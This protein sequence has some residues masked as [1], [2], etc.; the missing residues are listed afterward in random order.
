MGLIPKKLVYILFSTLL[1]SAVI[2]F[3]SQFYTLNVSAATCSRH[4][5]MAYSKTVPATCSKTGSK[6]TYCGN[7]SGVVSTKTIAKLAHTFSG[8]YTTTKAATCTSTGTKVGKCSKCSAVVSTVTIAKKS[9]SYTTLKPKCNAE[10]NSKYCTKCKGSYGTTIA[11]TSH[12]WSTTRNATCIAEGT[13]KCGGCNKTSSISKI[14]HKYLSTGKCAQSGCTSVC[15]HS[16]VSTVSV[17]PN[18][19]ISDGYSKTTCNKCNKVVSNTTRPKAAHSYTVIQTAATCKVAGIKKCSQCPAT[20][21][22]GPLTTHSSV[23]H[24]SVMATC[25][26]EGYSKVTCNICNTVVQNNVLQK[27]EHNFANGKCTGTNCTET[28]MLI[29]PIASGQEAGYQGDTGLDINANVGTDVYAAASGTII[30]SEYGHTEWKPTSVHP[31]D[32]PYSVLIKLDKP[33]TYNGKTAYYIWYTHLS[34]I[35]NNVKDGSTPSIRVNTGQII[36]KSGIGRSSPHLHFG[37]IINRDQ[38]TTN[39]YFS[40]EEVRELLGLKE[41]QR[42]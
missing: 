6:T 17:A 32:T 42:I 31:N 12:A 4:G 39:D 24:S 35:I 7:C 33:I 41:N 8:S 16:S 3:S 36:G 23:S 13:K 11:K 2:F 14:A 27:L 15:S 1:F 21:S 26:T 20:I 40:M 37:V 28:L 5:Y 29:I 30:Y 38:K 10:G 34:S 9:H 18:K 25:T 22:Y 19:C